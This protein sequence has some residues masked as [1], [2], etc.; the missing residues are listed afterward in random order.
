LQSAFSGVWIATLLALWIH[1]LGNFF[2]ILSL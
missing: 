2:S 1:L